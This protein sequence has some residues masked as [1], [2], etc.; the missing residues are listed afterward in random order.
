MSD[1]PNDKPGVLIF[2]PLLFAICLACGA[3]AHFVCPYRLALSP[4]LRGAGG[5]LAVAAIAFALRAQRVMRAAG[6]NVHPNLP[7]TAIVSDGPFAITRNP[8]YLTLL[9]VFAGI[10]VAAASPAFLTL[11][12]P[13]ALVLHFGVVQREERYLETKFGDTYR[14]YKARVRRWI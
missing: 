4:W 14:D 8:L 7:A 5:V 13:L 10:G 11:I 3:I 6:T 1:A 12:V 2:P 9:A